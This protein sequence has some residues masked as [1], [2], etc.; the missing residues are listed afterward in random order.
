MRVSAPL[1]TV[2]GTVAGAVAAVAAYQAGTG[3]P[4]DAAAPTRSQPVVSSVTAAPAPATRTTWLP[5]EKGTRLRHGACV[6]VHKKIVVVEDPAPVVAAPAVAAS[7]EAVTSGSAQPAHR[8]AR[9]RPDQSRAGGTREPEHDAAESR[10]DPVRQDDPKDTREHEHR[11][12]PE[13]AQ[14]PEHEDAPA[15]PEDQDGPEDD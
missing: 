9:T 11:D 4:A 10:P 1:L 8:A 7:A 12:A 3:T 14:S 13:H 15:P 2:V 5:C 6:K